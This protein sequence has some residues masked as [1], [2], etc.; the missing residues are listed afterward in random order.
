MAQS[1]TEANF[2]CNGAIVG[3]AKRGERRVGVG[4]E[5]EGRGGRRG[6]IGVDERRAL[7]VAKTL[8][9]KRAWFVERET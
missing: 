6:A 5:E 7:G 1:K 2:L 4:R 8:R 3:D 9:C